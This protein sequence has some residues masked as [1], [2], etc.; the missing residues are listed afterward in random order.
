M[1]G[2]P[3]CSILSMHSK[4]GWRFE[5]FLPPPYQREDIIQMRKTVLLLVSM[6]LASVVAG[7][8]VL[9]ATT[10]RAI[11]G[12]DSAGR[13]GVTRATSRATPSSWPPARTDT[14]R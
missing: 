7:G 11:A 8:A 14:V 10:L 6:A 2:S 1:R 4:K 12:T 9:G 5:T 13:C 3:T